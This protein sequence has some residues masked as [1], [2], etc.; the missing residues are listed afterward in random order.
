M[1]I[2]FNQSATADVVIYPVCTELT[3][4]AALKDYTVAESATKWME[5]TTF[6]QPTN[7]PDIVLVGLGERDKLTIEKIRQAAGT[8]GRKLEKERAVAV[9][10]D[11][12]YIRAWCDQQTVANVCA[13]WVEGWVLGTYVFDQYKSK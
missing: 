5:V 1:K 3:E 9:Q 2:V 12:T 10:V 11:F 4:F 13:A 6:Y 8:V 7:H